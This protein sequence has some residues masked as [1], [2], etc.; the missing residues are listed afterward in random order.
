MENAG[1]GHLPRGLHLPV[2]GDR[3]PAGN[4]RADTILHEMAHM[5][6]GDLVTMRWWDDLWLNESFADL[7]GH[8]RPG[9]GDPL[10]GCLDHLRP[11][12]EDLGL[13]AG[14]AAVHAPDRRRHPRHRG[15]RGQLRRHHLRQG[16][17]GA[18][19]AGRLC[20]PGQLPGRRA[21]LLRQARLG[22]RHPGRPARRA[23]AVVRPR[24]DV[25]VEVVAGDGRGE[26][27]AAVLRA[28]RRRPVH[29]RS[30]CC[31]KRRPATRSCARTVWRSACTTGP[32]PA[33]D[34]APPGRARRR[35]A[36]HRGARA[37]RPAAAGPDPGQ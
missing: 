27:A 7:G 16:R 19:A 20:R 2:Q 3:C 25:L 26:H 11:G 30:A 24:P 9:R 35:R 17:F 4:T 15:G 31:R 34:S 32:T 14:P 23:G 22:Q 13:P 6:F 33:T 18:Q 37:R 12:L 36:A 5:W 29:A 10:A 21:R 8:R 1:C 28:G